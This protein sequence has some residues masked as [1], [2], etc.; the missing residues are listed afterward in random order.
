MI[1]NRRT[2]RRSHEAVVSGD[3]RKQENQEKI[4]G[5]CSIRR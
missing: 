2:R 4:I 5:N 3:D 1:E